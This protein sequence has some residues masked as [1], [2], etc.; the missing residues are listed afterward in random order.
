MR[1][2]IAKAELGELKRGD[3]VMEVASHGVHL[4]KIYGIFGDNPK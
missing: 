3:Y 4:F 2:L 1:D